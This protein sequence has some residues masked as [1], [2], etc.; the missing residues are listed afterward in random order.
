MEDVGKRGEKILSEN[1][2]PGE[3]IKVKLKGTFGEAFVV[4]TTRIYVAK[5]GF[6][7]GNT[8]GGRCNAFEFST[9]TGIEYKKSLLNGTVEVQTPSMQ[10]SQKSY[11]GQGQNSAITADNIVNFQRKKFDIFMEATNLARE[12]MSKRRNTL[13]STSFAQA[14]GGEQKASENIQTDALAHIEKLAELRDKGILTEEEFT[15]KKKQ[16][17][18][19]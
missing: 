11:W 1:I 9:I 16:L 18:G 10:N 15:A 6:Q 12:M 14:L 3:T 19:I 4:T 17:L 7:T 13:S 5:W 8:F 2:Q